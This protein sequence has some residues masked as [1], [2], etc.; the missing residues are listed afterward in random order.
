MEA[1]REQAR[2]RQCQNK[3]FTLNLVIALDLLGNLLVIALD[4]LGNL[5]LVIALDQLISPLFDFVYLIFGL[6]K[7]PTLVGRGN[8]LV[9][10]TLKAT[11]VRS[12]GPSIE[13][14]AKQLPM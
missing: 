12:T 9:E 2:D 7:Y 13:I 10:K 4:L 14:S 3:Q 8:F 11:V 1:K 6:Q 5:N